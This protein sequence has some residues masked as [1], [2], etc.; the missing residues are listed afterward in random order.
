MSN[1]QMSN[2]KSPRN[3]NI[4]N[5]NNPPIYNNQMGNMNTPNN[6]NYNNPPIYNNQMTNSWN[7]MNNSQS[8]N[9]YM[10]QNPNQ[11]MYQGNTPFGPN[12][13]NQ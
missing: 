13:F 12:N 1:I 8:M 7:Q 4:N 6:Y 2:M 11:Q 10:N 5:Y 9:N 3:P